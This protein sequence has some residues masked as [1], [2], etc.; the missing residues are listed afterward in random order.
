MIATCQRETNRPRPAIV[1]LT[2]L[3]HHTDDRNQLSRLQLMIG[4]IQLNDLS[5]PGGALEWYEQVDGP[6][7][8]LA[9]A[10]QKRVKTHLILDQFDA[11]RELNASALDHFRFDQRIKR[12][13][14]FQLASLL[15]FSLDFDRCQA[16]LDSLAEHDFIGSTYNDILRKMR[17]LSSAQDK[18][19][20]QQ[21]AEAELYLLQRKDDA[22]SEIL[23]QLLQNSDNGEILLHATTLLTESTNPQTRVS[24]AELTDLLST[25]ILRLPDLIQ[26]DEISYQRDLLLDQ[27]PH[28]SGE[29]TA[30][31][32]QF[33]LDYPR[34]PRADRVRTRVRAMETGDVEGD[35]N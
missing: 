24:T 17:L 27:K 28:N 9:T 18:S 8:W 11:A 7:T 30:G 16:L 25:V 31:W 14:D 26:L 13:L 29:A 32:E 3:L 34:S 5:D 12:Q 22:A 23:L 15:Y 33:L 20:L 21:L 35:M 2:D 4:D 1:T 6:G 19:D 10:Y